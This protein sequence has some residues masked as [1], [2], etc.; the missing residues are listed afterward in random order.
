VAEQDRMILQ[1][2]QLF[3][4][5]RMHAK[6]RSY[7]VDHAPIVTAPSVVLDLL[8]EAISAVQATSAT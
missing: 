5:E 6:V 2:N 8:R 7:A 4:A 1:N 3:M